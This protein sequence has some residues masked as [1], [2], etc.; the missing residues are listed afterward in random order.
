VG[1]RLRRRDVLFVGAQYG[2]DQAEFRFTHLAASSAITAFACD[3]PRQHRRIRW[4]ETG[5]PQAMS[6]P[7]EKDPDPVAK[8]D[9][10]SALPGELT[11]SVTLSPEQSILSGPQAATDS[12]REPAASVALKGEPSAH[13][14]DLLALPAATEK[15]EM[16]VPDLELA[17]AAA[18]MLERGS[19]SSKEPAQPVLSKSRSKKKPVQGHFSWLQHKAAP[20]K[21]SIF[22]FFGL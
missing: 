22:K 5:R 21:S 10:S 17:R 2:L 19:D 9:A 15:T 14:R 13:F 7:E 16:T 4:G 18:A 6:P 1:R 20:I 3:M 8:A 11:P 12:S